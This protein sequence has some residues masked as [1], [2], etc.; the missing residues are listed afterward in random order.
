MLLVGQFHRGVQS[1]MVDNGV[2]Y[3]LLL[4]VWVTVG[5]H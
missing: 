4:S 1:A 2:K 5:V 3:E